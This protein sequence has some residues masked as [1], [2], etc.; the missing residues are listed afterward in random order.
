MTVIIL[1][2]SPAFGSKA[3]EIAVIRGVCK[4]LIRNLFPKHLW[5]P[6]IY[7]CALQEILTMKG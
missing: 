2:R 1:P 7:D 6:N 4:T 5:E 3:E